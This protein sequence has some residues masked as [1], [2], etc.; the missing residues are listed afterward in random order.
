MTTSKDHYGAGQL[1]AMGFD[2]SASPEERLKMLKELRGRPGADDAAVAH[3]LGAIGS[4]EA[5]AILGEMAATATGATRREVRRALFKLRQRGIVTESDTAPTRR[6]PVE[7]GES[8]LSALLSPTDSQGTRVVWL[9]KSRPGGIKRLSCL[10][11]E[12]EGMLA[13]SLSTVS[14]K[15]LRAERAELELRVGVRFIEADWHL[16]DFIATDAY[17]HTPPARRVEVGS[18]LTTRAEMTAAAPATGLEHP[19]Y[20]ELGTQANAEPS[21]DLMKE[22]EIAGWHLPPEAVKSYADEVQSLR[23]SMIV[24]NRMQQEDRVNSVVERAIAEL[25]VDDN[26]YRLRRH[27]EDTAYYLAHSGR[28]RQAGWTAAAAMRIREGADLR[29]IPFFQHLMRAQ[30]GAALAEEEEK[31]REEPRLVMTPAEAIRAQQQ[32]RARQRR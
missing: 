17:R 13:A 6:R 21:P 14:R 22:P 19:I 27:L 23:Q 7:M 25:L 8:G 32:A 12:T 30:L 29:Y 2:P 4:A 28:K 20:S 26:A 1:R 3:E 31:K 9:M 24:L 5:A 10:V 15:E 18:F 16:A 11:S